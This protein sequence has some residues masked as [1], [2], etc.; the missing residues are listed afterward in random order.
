MVAV[1]LKKKKQKKRKE[2]EFD[3]ES[4]KNKKSDSHNNI[5]SKINAKEQMM[6]S[7]Q[8]EQ[9]FTL[10][11][12]EDSSKTDP[13][14]LSTAVF[15]TAQITSKSKGKKKSLICKDKLAEST[16]LSTF[17]PAEVQTTCVRSLPG[18]RSKSTL[19]SSDFHIK[20][21]NINHSLFHLKDKSVNSR[22]MSGNKEYTPYSFE[23][24]SLSFVSDKDVESLAVD[25]SSESSRT[26]HTKA[27]KK[28]ERKLKN[29]K[30]GRAHV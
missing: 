14:H 15:S 27:K 28:K 25:K 13:Q 12:I 21:A 3:T 30:I 11:K 20:E 16:F 22:I 5:P 23:N 18:Y 8:L 4:N 26:K 1:S 6:K 10:G 24:S 17:T 19:S 9:L 2:K 7:V 29:F